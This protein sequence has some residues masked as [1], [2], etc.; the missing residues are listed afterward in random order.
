MEICGRLQPSRFRIRSA[1]DR[2]PESSW[3]VPE[4]PASARGPRRAAASRFGSGIGGP[5]VTGRIGGVVP[6]PG[7]ADEIVG[8]ASVPT[9]ALAVAV[10]CEVKY[11]NAPTA[12][13]SATASPIKAA[14]RRLRVL[15]WRRITSARS[16]CS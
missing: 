2:K 3:G 9:F 6:A 10:P 8:A 13:N 12:A 11:A 15:S 7:V 14:D 5:P 16:R 1:R 4:K